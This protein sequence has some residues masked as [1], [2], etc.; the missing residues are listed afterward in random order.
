MAKDKPPEND[1]DLFR[2]MMTGVKPL[3][4]EERIQREKPNIS[5]HRRTQTPEEQ[6]ESSFVEL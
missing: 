2:S 6:I 5:P 1:T 3:A 4:T